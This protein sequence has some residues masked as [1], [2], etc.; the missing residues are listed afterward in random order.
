[1]RRNFAVLSVV[2]VLLTA[3]IPA[4]SGQE[5]EGPPGNLWV[6]SFEEAPLA[7]YAGG[8]PGLEATNPAVRGERKLNSRTQASIDYL[9]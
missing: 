5:W 7:T 9:A 4:A 1:M 3:T 2:F 6:V 8:V